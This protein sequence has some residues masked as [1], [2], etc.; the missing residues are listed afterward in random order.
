MK[1]EKSKKKAQIKW[2]IK[3]VLPRFVLCNSIA[4]GSRRYHVPVTTCVLLFVG[5]DCAGGM[6]S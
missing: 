5:P 1:I 3:C 6:S 4:P 2:L